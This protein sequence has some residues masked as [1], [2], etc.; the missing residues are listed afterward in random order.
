MIR[1]DNTYQENVGLLLT[2]TSI[3]VNIITN[4]VGAATRS[5]T[6]TLRYHGRALS[7]AFRAS[8]ANSATF[9]SADGLWEGS[10]PTLEPR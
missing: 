10:A 5:G 7:A 6:L 2:G 3:A 1:H 4:K 8:L 9:A